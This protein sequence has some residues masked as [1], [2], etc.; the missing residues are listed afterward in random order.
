MALSE[1]QLREILERAVNAPSG[2]NCQPWTFSWDGHGL[3]I[4]YDPVRG[5][6]P[7]NPH[8]MMSILTLG[9]LLE[10]IEFAAVDLKHRSV[11]QIA[12]VLD[13]KTSVW[14]TVL[15]EPLSQPPPTWRVDLSRQLA[16]RSTD[17]RLFQGGTIPADLLADIQSDVPTEEPTA[18]LHVLQSASPQFA[19]VVQYAVDA[20]GLLIVHPRILPATLEW[21]R[22]TESMAERTRDGMRWRNLGI[23][24]WQ[25]PLIIAIRYYPVILRVIKF[26]ML[27]QHRAAAAKQL[28][29][30]AGLV[31]VA[32]PYPNQA[33]D[34][35][36]AGRLM[37]RAWLK[38]TAIGYGVQPL[39]LASAI[40]F[41]AQ[42]PNSDL[43]PRWNRFFRNHLPLLRKSFSLS[44]G[45]AVTW[46]FRTGR[47]TPLPLALRTLRR[48]IDW[49]L[50]QRVPQSETG[51][52]Q[53][54]SR[55][56]EKS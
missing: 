8:E 4:I 3:Q 51:G 56:T 39:S 37:L 2:D 49:V 34:L 14:A 20:E 38:L 18:R 40:S 46:M 33:G 41:Y 43:S 42:S 50:T 35:V 45:T 32:I 36:Q 21:V 12:P 30:S 31:A 19:P 6:H 23:Q 10:A 22:W 17:R 16:A 53:N 44:P 48:P 7:L 29:S 26:L 1:N 9:C 28:R 52:I 55:P 5:R 24:I 15:F 25:L 54:D 27:G 11:P 13:A 47:A